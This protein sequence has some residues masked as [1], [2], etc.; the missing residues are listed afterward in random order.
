LPAHGGPQGASSES[1]EALDDLVV[2]PL[3]PS[4]SELDSSEIEAEARLDMLIGRRVGALALDFHWPL[5]QISD[6]LA[7]IE[8]GF[9]FFDRASRTA[10]VV[11]DDPR[12]M[13]ELEFYRR[14]VP[15][16]ME[17]A[18]QAVE[19]LNTHRTGLFLTAR[20][21]SERHLI[22]SPA[23]LVEQ[24]AL[25]G[26]P[27]WEPHFHFDIS[28]GGLS[29]LRCRKPARPLLSA[30]ID[31]CVAIVAHRREAKNRTITLGLYRVDGQALLYLE[32]RRQFAHSEALETAIER[33]SRRLS[34]H[35]WA[36]QS[37]QENDAIGLRV[38]LS[39]CLGKPGAMPGRDS[40]S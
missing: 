16:A 8:A 7:F 34:Q 25:I 28:I 35:G 23:S 37:W 29:T 18:R 12:Q 39:E 17:E 19:L 32:T 13:A 20:S 14:E 15:G 22:W 1:V 21:A 36:A 31:L 40:E 5:V 27:I 10:G 3:A 30:L 9:G 2:E 6:T 11:S 33:V 24:C 4:A 38:M 26:E